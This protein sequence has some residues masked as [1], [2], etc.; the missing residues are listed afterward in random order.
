MKILAQSSA[1]QPAG[2]RILDEVTRAE[3]WLKLI[4]FDKFIWKIKAF[5][6]ARVNDPVQNFN[7]F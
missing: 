6:A 5:L 4:G 3:I 2:I 7:L 1:S